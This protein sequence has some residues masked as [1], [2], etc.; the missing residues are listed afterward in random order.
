MN[1]FAPRPDQDDSEIKGVASYYPGRCR[2]S[3]VA[4]QARI[5]LLAGVRP[6][7]SSVAELPRGSGA[8]QRALLEG[9]NR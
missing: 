1:T 4:R 2:A 3:R 6:T 5:H 7:C 9:M 8:S